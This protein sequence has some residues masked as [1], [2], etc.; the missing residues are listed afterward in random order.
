ML[1]SHYTTHVVA[2][3]FMDIVG[4]HH[5]MHRS[6]VSNR[7]P[8]FINRFWQELFKLSG[9]KLHMS[10]SYHPQSDGQ[11]EV[12][13]RFCTQQTFYLGKIFNVGK[14]VLQHLKT[15]KHWGFT[16]WGDLWKKKTPTFPQYLVGT[17]RIEAVDDILTNKEV[18]FTSLKKKLLKPRKT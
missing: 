11:T 15:F 12:L 9:T 10:F 16:I 3:F 4:K 18:V 8:L 1:Q 6:L 14:M 13:N 7:D 2:L 17:S 5:G